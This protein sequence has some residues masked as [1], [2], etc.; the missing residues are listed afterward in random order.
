MMLD[1][2]VILKTLHAALSVDLLISKLEEMKDVSRVT[3]M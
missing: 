1:Q 2:D 3:E